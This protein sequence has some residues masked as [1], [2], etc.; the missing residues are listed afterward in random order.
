MKKKDK[1]TIASVVAVLIIVLLAL[2]LHV[3]TNNAVSGNSNS[4]SGLNA[5][6]SAAI[7]GT[8][9]V[10]RQTPNS[11]NK[12]ALSTFITSLASAKSGNSSKYDLGVINN[13][14]I[15]Y[16]VDPNLGSDA[17]M[18]FVVAPPTV[19]KVKPFQSQWALYL[20]PASGSNNSVLIVQKGISTCAQAIAVAKATPNASR[21]LVTAN[22]KALVKTAAL[23]L[24]STALTKTGLYILDEARGLLT[25]STK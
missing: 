16:Q 3:K 9:A 10:A 5:L 6:D 24:P 1:I 17:P 14:L 20:Q 11:S 8:L 18:C 22:S 4:T 7:T 13:Q 2:V 23:S 21:A 25:Q 19:A 12:S 15:D